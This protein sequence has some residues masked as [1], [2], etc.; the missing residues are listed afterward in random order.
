MAQ[1]ERA[2][3]K[4]NKVLRYRAQESELVQQK[5]QYIQEHFMQANR[6]E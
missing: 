6:S 1:H 4:F 5:L 3:V 2:F